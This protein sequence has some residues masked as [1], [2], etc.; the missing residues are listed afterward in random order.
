M[1]TEAAVPATVDPSVDMKTPPKEQIDS[2]PADKFFTYAAEILKQQDITDQPLLEHMKRI[3]IQ[4]GDFRDPQ[5]GHFNDPIMVIRKGGA[6]G[7]ALLA[8]ADELPA[9]RPRCRPRRLITSRRHAA[10][11][12][13]ELAV[14]SAD[15]AVISFLYPIIARR[16]RVCFCEEPH[17]RCAPKPLLTI[18][19]LL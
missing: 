2:M 12:M 7:I 11:D 14:T 9:I 8:A 19:K 3:G 6:K 5:S 16:R 10:C 4:R 1:S 13:M 17:P 15:E 18:S